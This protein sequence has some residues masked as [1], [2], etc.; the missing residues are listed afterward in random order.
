MKKYYYIAIATILALSI[1]C[2]KNEF[3]SIQEAEKQEQGINVVTVKGIVHEETET[4]TDYD[5]DWDSHQATFYW[6][7]AE[8]FS[9][10]FWNSTYVSREIYTGTA[11]PSGEPEITFTGNAVSN[12]SGYAFYPSVNKSNFLGWS[13]GLT[14]NY[15]L[16]LV[17]SSPYSD[18]NPIKDLV[19]MIGKLNSGGTAYEF[20]PVTGVLAVRITNIPSEATYIKISSPNTSTGGFSGYF[21]TNQ[22]LASYQTGIENAYNDGIQFSKGNTNGASRTF[23]F[24]NLSSSNT[25]YFYFPTPIGTLNGLQIELGDAVG[26]FFT[27]TSSKDVT[28]TK[29]VITR[30]PLI[31]VPTAPSATITGDLNDRTANFTYNNA[32]KIK[33]AITTSSTAHLSSLTPIE[34][35]STSAALAPPSTGT[36]YLVY[37]GYMADGTTK[38]GPEKRVQFIYA[39]SNVSQIAGTYKINNNNNFKLDIAAVDPV[40]DGKNIEITTYYSSNSSY[41]GATG[42]CYGVFDPETGTITIASGQSLTKDTYTYYLV[43]IN[44]PFTSPSGTYKDNF[45]FT[46]KGVENNAAIRFNS[47]D[48]KTDGL[49]VA[50]SITPENKAFVSGGQHFTS[51]GSGGPLYLYKAN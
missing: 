7:G 9:R 45:V 14:D 23:T 33:Y 40:Q 32:V 30:L 22:A 36:Y 19:P 25:Y 13:S 18:A 4:K 34:T 21:S 41:N 27:V 6:K 5:I 48:G 47:P 39:T 1:S 44:N 17:A 31:T 46:L 16:E 29:G 11:D 26:T 37:Q 8:E 28:S 42:H 38:V 3:Q 12:D 2:G 15:R 20:R 49:C 51:D 43:A 50:T 35:T 24:S 10:L